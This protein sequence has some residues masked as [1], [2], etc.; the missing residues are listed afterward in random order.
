MSAY[1]VPW[2]VWV[3]CKHRAAEIFHQGG[4]IVNLL[5]STFIKKK[6]GSR[7]GKQLLSQKY[8]LQKNK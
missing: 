1:L 2:N 8:G 3:Q 5:E 6:T 4:R 7:A